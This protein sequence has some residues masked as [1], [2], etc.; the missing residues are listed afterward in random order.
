M[1]SSS[2]APWLNTQDTLGLSLLGPLLLSLSS[3]WAILT[4]PGLQPLH[5]LMTLFYWLLEFLP[6]KWGACWIDTST[7]M[8]PEASGAAQAQ[9][10][11]CLPCP[12]PACTLSAI[13]YHACCPIYPSS[14]ATEAVTWTNQR[15]LILPHTCRQ[16]VTKSYQFYFLNILQISDFL[17]IPCCP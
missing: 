4:S 8:F 15:P 9:N 3:P 11:S 17:S 10:G 2:C 6:L 7:G 1:G 13:L 5:L 16:S 12:F 14:Y